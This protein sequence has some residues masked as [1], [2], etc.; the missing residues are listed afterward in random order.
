LTVKYCTNISL[1]QAREGP[2]ISYSWRSIV[3]GLQALQVG[4]IWRVGDGSQIKIWEDPWIHNGVSR[5][6]ITPK[7]H[8]LVTKVAE[9]LNPESG[10][11]DEEM[12]RDIFWTEDVRHILATPTSP[13]HEDALA[14]HFDRRGQFS[15]KSAY[16]MLDD[17]K[18]WAKARQ[19]GETSSSGREKK[20]NGAI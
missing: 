18:H 11:W 19:A 1:L 9:L 14:W 13:G 4:L 20:E 16:H 2:G 10:T 8:T 12:V 3:R 7:G 6:P 17:A 5:R 15:V